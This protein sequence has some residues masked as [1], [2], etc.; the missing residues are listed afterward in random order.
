[1]AAALIDDPAL[2]AFTGRVSGKGRSTIKAAI[3]E[4]VP[5]HVLSSPL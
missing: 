3:D 2:S 5:A 4:G 1:L